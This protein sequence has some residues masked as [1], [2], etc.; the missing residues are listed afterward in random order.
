MR[1]IREEL[2]LSQLRR[3]ELQAAIDA[4]VSR[5]DK[6]NNRLKQ[7]EQITEEERDRL[8]SVPYAERDSNNHTQQ[9]G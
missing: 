6:L 5:I 4:L 9:N 8:T 3:Q 1:K 2:T 7:H